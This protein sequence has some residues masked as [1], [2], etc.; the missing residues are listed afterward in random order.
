MVA[1]CQTGVLMCSVGA[2]A[3]QPIIIMGKCGSMASS[4]HVTRKARNPDFCETPRGYQSMSV[5][6][7]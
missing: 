5:V 1:P 7:I 4:S 3:T 2:A 6:E